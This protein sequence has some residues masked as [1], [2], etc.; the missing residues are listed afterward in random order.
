MAG[1]NLNR[2]KRWLRITSP[3][4]ALFQ[5]KGPYYLGGYCFGGNV[6]YEMA[7]I[8]QQ[9]G[10]EVALLALINSGPPNSSYTEVR[11]SP[12]FA[13]KF[14]R[15]LVYW[16][17][18]ATTWSAKQRKDFVRWKLSVMWKAI[19]RRFGNGQPRSRC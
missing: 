5:A 7:R 15:N 2:S 4:C 18:Y 6:A 11:W 8:L 14:C 9:Q 1:R 19:H 13:L 10:E 16:M 17:R 12:S 3:I